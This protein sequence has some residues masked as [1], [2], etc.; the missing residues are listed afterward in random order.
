MYILSST[1]HQ[2]KAQKDDKAVKI[3]AGI[4]PMATQHLNLSGMY[5]Y[6]EGT[7]INIDDIIAALSQAAD[8]FFNKKKK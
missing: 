4:S 3:L 2:K 1:I 5:H 8:N 6:G 7:S